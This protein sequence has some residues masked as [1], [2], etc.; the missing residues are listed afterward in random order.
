MVLEC[1]A[2]WRLKKGL[3]VNLDPSL[4]SAHSQLRYE[5]LYL[6]TYVK[7]I[8]IYIEVYRVSTIQMPKL[9]K[10]VRRERKKDRE[11]LVNFLQSVLLE[12]ESCK[13]VEIKK[14]IVTIYA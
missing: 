2:M 13:K 12:N 5:H 8:Y 14:I 4:L 1:L 3:I 6:Y 7:Y 10:H 9:R 11:T